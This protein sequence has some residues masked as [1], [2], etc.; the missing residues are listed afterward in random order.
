MAKLSASGEWLV[1][2]N[3]TPTAGPVELKVNSKL[4]SGDCYLFLAFYK[5][6]MNVKAHSDVATLITH[7]Q[8]H[9]KLNILGLLNVEESSFQF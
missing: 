6:C 3:D 2:D 8:K 9:I 4:R 7:L 1:A 5:G